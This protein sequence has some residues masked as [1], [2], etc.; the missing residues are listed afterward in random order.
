MSWQQ[1]NEEKIYA[2]LGRWSG[3][4]VTKRSGFYGTTIVE[5]DIDLKLEMDEKGQL[6]Q[7]LT[8]H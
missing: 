5:V 1:R 3:H 2:L 7:V 4:S 6:I 8:A